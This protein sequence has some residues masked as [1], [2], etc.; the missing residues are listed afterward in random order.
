MKKMKK[1]TSTLWEARSRL[2]RTRLLQGN[3]QCNKDLARKRVGMKDL[4][5]KA[6]DEIYKMYILLHGSDLKS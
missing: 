6:L 1:I 2:Y 5:W 3:T 4:Y